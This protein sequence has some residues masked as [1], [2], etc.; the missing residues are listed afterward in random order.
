MEWSHMTLVSMLT[1][2]FKWHLAL[3]V[4][5]NFTGNIY[6]IWDLR[7]LG[8]VSTRPA[9][10]AGVYVLAGQSLVG[11]GASWAGFW[12]WREDQVAGLIT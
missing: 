11:S 2:F 9:V 8:Y 10:R 1:A 7:H 12:Y 5:S 6:S 3:T 4:V